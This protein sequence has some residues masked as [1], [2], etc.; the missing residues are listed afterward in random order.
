MNAK[1]RSS[2]TRTPFRS[3][4]RFLFLFVLMV[5]LAFACAPPSSAECSQWTDP[6]GILHLGND[7]GEDRI[8][9]KLQI[10]T[11]VGGRR[12]RMSPVGLLFFFDRVNWKTLFESPICIEYYYFISPYI[13]NI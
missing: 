4:A 2:P 5:G 12:T 6:Q 8:A 10:G 11:G 7:A 9:G 13:A 3:H 1:Q